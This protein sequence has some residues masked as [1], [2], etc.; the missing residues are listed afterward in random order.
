MDRLCHCGTPH[1]AKGLCA[2]HYQIERK[3][4]LVSGERSRICNHPNMVQ[5]MYRD[6]TY[7]EC[8]DCEYS[9]EIRP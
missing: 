9:K 7:D 2:K 3:R 8:Q 4:R 5:I 6:G 1:W